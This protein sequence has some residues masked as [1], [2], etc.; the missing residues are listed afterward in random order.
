MTTKN[1]VLILCT[2]FLFSG[3]ASLIYQVVWMR[4]LSL[5]FGS[6]IYAAS[7][8][9]SIFMGGLSLGSIFAAKVSDRIATPLLVYAAVEIGIG[10]YA[11]GFSKILYSFEPLYKI[12]YQNYFVDAPF[13]YQGFRIAVASCTLLIPTVLMGTTLPIIVRTFIREDEEL[14]AFVGMFY[15]VNTVGAL[16]GTVL[17]GFLLIPFLGINLTICC[18]VAINILVGLMSCLLHHFVGPTESPSSQ[19]TM[20]T[21]ES[22]KI[23]K[24]VLCVIFL[25]GLAALALEVVWFRILVQTFSATAYSFTIMLASFLLGITLGSRAISKTIDNEADPAGFLA[26]IELWLGASV[27]FLVFATFFVP[28][29]FGALVWRLVELFG[30]SFGVGS[31]VAKLIISIPLIMASTFLLGASFPAAVKAC[32]KGTESVGWITGRVYGYNTAGAIVGALLGGFV[33]IPFFGSSKSLFAIAVLFLCNGWYLA[34][35]TSKKDS[36]LIRFIFFLS[37]VILLS[38]LLLP[39]K[40][41]LNYNLQNLENYQLIY[42]QD[43]ISHTVSVVRR[44]NGLTIMAIGG[45]VEADTSYTQR[46]HFVLKG[47][48]P[49][50]LHESPKEVAVI[51][52]GLGITL[53]AT[54]RHPTIEKAQVIEL[55]PEMVTAHNHLKELTGDIMNNPKISLLIDDGRNFLSMTEKKF[56]MITADPIHPRISGVGYLYTQEYYRMIKACLNQGGVV[57]Q[58]MP[59]YHISPESFNVAFR[60]FA[61]VFDH[62]YFWYVRGHGLLVATTGQ[63]MDYQ[64]FNQRLSTPE[65]SGDMGTIDIQNGEQLLSYMLMGPKEIRAYLEEFKSETLNMDDNAYLEYFTPFEYLGKT[66]TIVEKLLPFAGI[67]LSLLNN[68]PEDKRQRIMKYWEIR[69]NNILPELDLPLR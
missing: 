55:S 9:L 45:N 35:K 56:D 8:T 6:D 37:S 7:I 10:I 19:E 40:L 53:S 42:S 61:S 38:S 34:R 57:C 26:E 69:Q 64:Q 32:S 22:S 5:F 50:L 20:R 31:S 59:M 21:R 13:L 3:L 4:Q 17:V 49:L 33:F 12:I 23:S 63:P 29:I 46:R 43:G 44:E 66:K 14:G 16:I 2:V 25:S 47:H 36:T 27:V 52:L 67:D 62:A 24:S 58:W 30:G 41:T 68:I 51:G 39:Q 65:V 18:A 28:D 60:T 1:K 54:V 15:S 48:L 11:L